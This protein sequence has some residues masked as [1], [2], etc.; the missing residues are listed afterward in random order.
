MTGFGLPVNLMLLPHARGST[1]GQRASMQLLLAPVTGLLALAL[2][3]SAWFAAVQPLAN[4]I[5][6]LWILLIVEWTI[7]L[8][9]HRH[10]IGDID[11]VAAMLRARVTIGHVVVGTGLALA[12]GVFLWPFFKD[13]RLVFWHY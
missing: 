2:T 7:L 3:I 4:A 11:K 6:P 8:A 10:W 12:I 1:T 13:P 5:V 9:R